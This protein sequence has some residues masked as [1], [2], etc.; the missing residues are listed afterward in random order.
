LVEFRDVDVDNTV[1]LTIV[2]IVSV[3]LWCYG[4]IIIIAAVIDHL[5]CA[6]YPPEWVWPCR[7]KSASYL[8]ILV[9]NGFLLVAFFRKYWQLWELSLLLFTVSV[10]LLGILSI[11][12]T[13]V[14]SMKPLAKRLNWL[15]S[16]IGRYYRSVY[17]AAGVSLLAV[18]VIVPTFGFFKFAHD[19]ASEMATKHQQLALLERRLSRAGRISGLNLWAEKWRRKRHDEAL[20]RYDTLALELFKVKDSSV[21]GNPREDSPQDFHLSFDQ[22]LDRALR[23]VPG[24]QL[25][26]EMRML[27][28]ESRSNRSSYAQFYELRHE[29]FRVSVSDQKVDSDRSLDASFTTLSASIVDGSWKWLAVI[30]V[31]VGCW[32]SLLTERMLFAGD[33]MP[34]DEVDWK[35]TDDLS[36]NLLVLCEA[37]RGSRKALPGVGYV[38]LRTCLLRLGSSVRDQRRVVVLDHFD[39]NMNERRS[40]VTRLQLLERLLYEEER[41]VIILSSLDPVTYLADSEFGVLADNNQA[42][43]ALLVRW[44]Q[45]MSSF[46]P[47]IL[48]TDPTRKKLE[49]DCERVSQESKE[50]KRLAEWVRKE[51]EHTPYLREVGLNVLA[52]PRPGGECNLRQLQQEVGACVRSYYEALWSTFTRGERLVLY[53]LSHDGWANPKNDLAILQL[54]RKGILCTKPMLRI[55]NESFR[56]FATKAQDQNEIGEWEREGKES[57][58]RTVRFS[59]VTIAFTLAVWLLYVQKDLFQAA[60][61]YIVALG[62]AVAA[63]SNLFGAFRG[64]PAAAPKGPDVATT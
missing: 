37:W 45:V 61:G 36:T 27:P 6:H 14:L 44:K 8:F 31:L 15:T 33:F 16:S 64:R 39:F 55:M 23:L 9:V 40:N 42:A 4:L 25:A 47:V 56:V 54:R 22:Y 30:M 53:Q 29:T 26:S 7:D 1:N 46:R 34:L 38:D 41:R 49:E 60:I 19:A 28:F 57:S 63:I 52:K 12:L 13:Y 20:D 35:T 17:V 5:R 3:L 18:T 2:L 58:W 48:I 24:S 51:C 21:G 62:A 59:L 32:V 43:A 11:F 10:A 50:A